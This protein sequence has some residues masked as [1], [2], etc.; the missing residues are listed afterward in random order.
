MTEDCE[1]IKELLYDYAEGRLSGEESAFVRKHILACA[2]CRAE[3]EAVCEMLS[4][5][6]DAEADVPPT[7]F[8]DVMCAVEKFEK[9]K[10]R[11]AAK[12]GFMR[13][14]SFAAAFA[15]VLIG[16]ALAL[17]DVLK[18]MDKPERENSDG[19]INDGGVTNAVVFGSLD[20]IKEENSPES[21]GDTVKDSYD[22]IYQSRPSDSITHYPADSANSDGEAECVPPSADNGIGVGDF[23]IDGYPSICRLYQAPKSNYAVFEKETDML[24]YNEKLGYAVLK[25][26]EQSIRLLNNNAATV[27]EDI[28][29]ESKKEILSD[30]QKQINLMVDSEGKA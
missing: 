24:I 22:S 13:Y 29:N 4:D 6:K 28:S 7:L 16:A 15:V 1:K 30:V 14:G 21:S 23:G 5:M 19:A 17:P 12:R 18:H 27:L 26:T 10:K 9:E 25:A 20:D 2:D 11:A 3:H 8:G